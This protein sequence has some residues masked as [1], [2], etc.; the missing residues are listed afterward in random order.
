MTLETLVSSINTISHNMSRLEAKLDNNER[1]AQDIMNVVNVREQLSNNDPHFESRGCLGEISE[2]ISFNESN[3][4]VFTKKETYSNPNQ[5]TLFGYTNTFSKRGNDEPPTIRT[6][7]LVQSTRISDLGQTQSNVGNYT[8]G[9]NLFQSEFGNTQLSYNQSQRFGTVN[10]IERCAE[11][12]IKDEENLDE[13]EQEVEEEFTETDPELNE[14]EMRDTIEKKLTSTNEVIEIHEGEGAI[15]GGVKGKEVDESTRRDLTGRST[16]FTYR[17]A[18][19]ET[20]GIENLISEAENSVSNRGGIT[21]LLSAHKVKGVVEENENTITSNI[22]SLQGEEENSD[23]VRKSQRSQ[24]SGLFKSYGLEGIYRSI[25]HA[26][27]VVNSQE[28]IPE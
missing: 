24:L 26:D 3:V 16:G 10:L 19:N 6:D 25:H 9:S 1:R 18:P 12:R 21:G 2:Q 13:I 28:E 23:S 14:D 15:V 17:P 7:H 8:Q 20:I 27:A 11:D 4:N 5:S 22:Q